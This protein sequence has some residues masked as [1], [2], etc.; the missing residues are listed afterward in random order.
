MPYSIRPMEGMDIDQVSAIEREAFSTLWPPTSYRRE[1]KNK[2]AEYAVCVSDGEFVAARP[3][4]SK[5]GLLGLF[6]RRKKQ[7]EP[8]FVRRQLVVGFVGVWFMAGECHIVAI[9]VREQYRRKGLGE[10]L[11]IGAIEMAMRRGQQVMTLEA[12]VSNE[13]AKALYTKY[14]FHEMG[15][16]R[17]Y[18]S[19]NNEDAVI[20]TTSSL[21]SAEYQELFDNLRSLFEERYG[22][23]L[24]EYM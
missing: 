21:K 4:R 5:R 2:Q 13:S 11:L 23:A 20:M 9:A 19:D 7:T 12:R 8:E 6:R 1:L 15:V 14:G 22:E 10:L 17:R 16:R 3:E 24:R 18:Y